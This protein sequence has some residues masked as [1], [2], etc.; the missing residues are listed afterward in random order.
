M[1][2]TVIGKDDFI[3]E[4]KFNTFNDECN[5]EI[6]KRQLIKYNNNLLKLGEHPNNN[7]Q[8]LFNKNLELDDRIYAKKNTNA[9]G[10]FTYNFKPEIT[11]GQA[12]VM[13]KDIINKKWLQNNEYYYC[14]EQRGTSIETM[15]DGLHVHLL[16]KKPDGK[17]PQHCKNECWNVFKKFC[18][19]E[20]KLI[21]EKHFKFIPECWK[22]DKIDY[23]S[24]TK[25]KDP[26]GSKTVKV[27]FDKI[28]REK[29]NL[30]ELYR[31]L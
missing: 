21:F 15:G 9:Y 4:I 3:N 29:N 19:L 2:T 18:D 17:S 1:N 28:Y 25:N 31:G 20:P 30:K 11:L 5:K 22:A 26:D 10:F 12:I 14:Y 13:M 6:I 23:I 7:L 24:G 16:F 27:K 8:K